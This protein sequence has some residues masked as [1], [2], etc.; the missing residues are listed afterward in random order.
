ML[1]QS[2]F[3]LCS[4][5]FAPGCLNVVLGFVRIAASF[6][7]ITPRARWT[8]SDMGL[9]RSGILSRSHVIMV[10]SKS[11]G[12]SGVDKSL[13]QWLFNTTPA[14][15]HFPPILS[16]CRTWY[17][18]NELFTSSTTQLI[19]N[20]IYVLESCTSSFKFLSRNMPFHGPCLVTFDSHLVH[21]QKP[22]VLWEVNRARYLR[23]PK[24]SYHCP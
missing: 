15:L 16:G 17:M 20:F 6:Q 13:S 7:K 12:S 1:A 3:V 23:H 22:T 5:L 11:P 9:I 14:I 10:N 2:E 21:L 4:L 8:C 18:F 19:H 24:K